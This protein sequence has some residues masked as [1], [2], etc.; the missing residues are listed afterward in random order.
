MLLQPKRPLKL[1]RGN[2][3][4]TVLP[5]QPIRLPDAVGKR[6]LDQAPD[7]VKRVRGR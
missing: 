6:L 2:V 3:T 1:T 7:R 5:H 4:V